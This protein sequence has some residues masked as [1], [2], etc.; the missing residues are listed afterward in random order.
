MA[1]YSGRTEGAE[2]EQAEADLLD[3]RVK[4]LVATSALGMGFDKPDLGFV[5]HLG[6]PPSPIAYYQ[7]VGRAGRAVDSADVL[8]LPGPEDEAIWR[9]FASLA[10]PPPE[11]VDRV[12]EALAAADRPLSTPGAGGPGRPAPHPARADAQGARRG[13][14]GAA[15]QGRLDGDRCAWIYDGDRYARVAAGPGGRGGGH[16]RVRR[17]PARAGWSSCARQLDDPHAAPC[18]RCDRCAGPWY[19]GAVLRRRR[20]TPPGATSAGPAWRSSPAGCGRPAPPRS[21]SPLSGKIAPGEAAEAGRAL[22]R[23]SDLGWGTRLRALV[24]PASATPRCRRMSSR[25]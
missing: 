3:N 19:D 23:L 8:L 11:Q 5:V 15:G 4:A 25:R 24:G 7:Q 21:A 18:G 17:T 14:R 9:Y 20:S 1:A 16:A 10:F 13:R 22:G 12:L 6:A 2:R